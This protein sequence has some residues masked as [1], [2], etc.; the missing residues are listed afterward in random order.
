M[1]KM[2]IDWSE[3]SLP[4]IL[5]ELVV[6]PTHSQ[7]FM[8]SAATWNR[9]HIHYSR[10]AAIAEGLEDIVVQRA[11]IGNF[12]VRLLTNW[13]GDT[14]QVKNISWRVLSSAIPNRKLRCQGVVTGHDSALDPDDLACEMTII[15]DAGETVATARA[16]VCIQ[17]F[18]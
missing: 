2:G 1:S 16:T 14:G 11:L 15:N 8:F 18:S 7:I 17:D 3:F 10:D 4:T 9:H 13:L 6:T 5:P 12:F